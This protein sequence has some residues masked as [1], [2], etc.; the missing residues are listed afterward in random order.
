MIGLL[1]FVTGLVLACY[2]SYKV[3]QYDDHMG[4]RPGASVDG[5]GSNISYVWPYTF[6][7]QIGMG[8]AIL[9]PLVGL[10]LQ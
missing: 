10:L 4:I 8:M 7:C 6:F 1:M 3:D 2:G 5:Y 9:A